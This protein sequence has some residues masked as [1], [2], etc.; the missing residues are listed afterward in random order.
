MRLQPP[1]PGLLYNNQSEY[2]FRNSSSLISS[3]RPSFAIDDETVLHLVFFLS[4]CTF[5]IA[6]AYKVGGRMAHQFAIR[7]L[8]T[9]NLIHKSWTTAPPPP[10]NFDNDLYCFP[11]DWVVS[12]RVLNSLKTLFDAFCSLYHNTFTH[13]SVN[14]DLSRRT[15]ICMPGHISRYKTLNWIQKRS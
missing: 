4:M 2:G 10:S 5:C 9:D 13:W 11:H 1:S 8:T 12:V 7:T 15:W 14:A 6:L 3:R